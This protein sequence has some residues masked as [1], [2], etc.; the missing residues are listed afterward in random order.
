M[1]AV[2][3]L[4][5]AGRP[6]GPPHLTIIAYKLGGCNCKFSG[7][8]HPID[9]SEAGADVRQAAG[10]VRDT[11]Q[12]YKRTTCCP[13]D[14]SDHGVPASILLTRME[15]SPGT[16]PWSKPTAFSETSG[17]P[18]SPARASATPSDRP[19]SPARSRR[20]HG[21]PQ[22]PRRP[23]P[24]LGLHIHLLRRGLAW[25]RAH[26][27]IDFHGGARRHRMGHISG[28]SWL[29]TGKCGAK[30]STKALDGATGVTTPP[31]TPRPL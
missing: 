11:G 14:C 16:M 6:A 4:R 25:W 28:L 31:R 8:N 9:S 5:P 22:G 21:V 12:S 24:Q 30:H 18:R 1:R 10:G 15:L 7:K 2:C 27:A 13:N 26:S 19:T 17:T 29:C 20:S 3:H 23:G